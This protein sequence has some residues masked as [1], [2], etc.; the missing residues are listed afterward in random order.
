MKSGSN[1][2]FQSQQRDFLCTSRIRFALSY[3]MLSESVI[4][5]ETTLLCLFY[6]FA[7]DIVIYRIGA[8]LCSKFSNNHEF[9]W[10]G[11]M[12]QDRGGGTSLRFSG[13]VKLSMSNIIIW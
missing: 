11:L 12:H 3:S 4:L 7:N 8:I 1:V 6:E 9:C 2:S 5:F 10:M 13:L